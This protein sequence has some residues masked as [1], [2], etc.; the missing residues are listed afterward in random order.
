MQKGQMGDI[1]IYIY[2]YIYRCGAR[3]AAGKLQPAVAGTA[4][5]PLKLRHVSKPLLVGIEREA[6]NRLQQSLVYIKSRRRPVL[7]GNYLKG[8]PRQTKS[9]G[10]PYFA[11]G[12]PGLGR[13]K[14]LA[15]YHA[16]LEDETRAEAFVIAAPNKKHHI[17]INSSLPEFLDIGLLGMTMN[18][19]GIQ[20]V[21]TFLGQSTRCHGLGSVLADSLSPQIHGV[22]SSLPVQEPRNARLP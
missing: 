14:G 2:I 7:A 11:V 8:S 16:D 1:C 19:S 12:F 20:K 10:D 6:Q 21:W 5:D 13:Y 17:K 4:L 15:Q 9:I 3:Q 22:A 18:F